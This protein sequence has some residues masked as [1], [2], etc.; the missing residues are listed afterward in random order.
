MKKKVLSVIPFMVV[1]IIIIINWYQM[2]F[3]NYAATL[4]HYI[5]LLLIITNA[6]WYFVKYKF[7]ILL[8]G[9][10]LILA[11]FNV[12]TFYAET[13]TV[14]WTPLIGKV[15]LSTPGIQG[16]SFLIFL[17]YCIINFNM[18][19][20]WYLDFKEAKQNKIK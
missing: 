13:T 8:T 3:G 2:I 18:L 15:Q 6:V 14:A 9:T 5:T 19:V 12:L 16:W 4:K 20:D 1:C 17:G 11:T 7:S 10:I